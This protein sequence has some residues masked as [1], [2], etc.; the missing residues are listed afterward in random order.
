MDFDA[1]KLRL[2]TPEEVAT[3]VYADDLENYQ[4]LTGQRAA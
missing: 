1:G 4:K 3:G 2:A